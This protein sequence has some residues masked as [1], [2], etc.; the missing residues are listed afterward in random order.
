MASRQPCSRRCGSLGL[1]VGS[2][3]K[4]VLCASGQ[5]GTTRQPLVLVL[6]AS[7]RLGAPK[8]PACMTGGPAPRFTFRPQRSYLAQVAQ[9]APATATRQ[10]AAAPQTGR[11]SAAHPP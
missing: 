2:R 4:F 11:L 9:L 5:A 7:G 3:H 10:L 6:G 8:A 1:C